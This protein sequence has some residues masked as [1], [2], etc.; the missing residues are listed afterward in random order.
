MPRAGTYLSV[1]L[2]Y[3]T[4]ALTR[5]LAISRCA[6]GLRLAHGRTGSWQASPGQASKKR[7]TC[8]RLAARPARTVGDRVPSPRLAQPPPATRRPPAG[9]RGWRGRRPGRPG[10]RGA[11]GRTRH[12]AP[13][14]LTPS[15]AG[16]GICGCRAQAGY[17]SWSGN[18]GA[19]LGGCS[20]QQPGRYPASPSRQ[21]RKRSRRP[22]WRPARPGRERERTR[23]PLSA[24]ARRQ[25][26]LGPGFVGAAAYFQSHA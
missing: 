26:P 16:R 4:A 10:R 19:G 8:P 15:R 24:Q 14:T 18:T 23:G 7:P 5:R 6:M 25:L 1:R 12:S 11:I 20:A 21:W 2:P 17:G 9:R 3:A 13:P 22:C